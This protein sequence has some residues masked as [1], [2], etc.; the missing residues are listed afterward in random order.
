MK[1]Q[2][3]SKEWMEINEFN[4]DLE[5]RF[6]FFST[7]FKMLYYVAALQYYRKIMEGDERGAALHPMYH[8]MI[9]KLGAYQ[10]EVLECE[11][12]VM[13]TLLHPTF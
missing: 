1:I 10:Q 3:T 2:F 11:T 4:E 13:A 8:K 5:V 12:L 9:E 7:G 6:F